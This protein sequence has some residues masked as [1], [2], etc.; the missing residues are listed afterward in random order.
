M[1]VGTLYFCATQTAYVCKLFNF[2]F[3]RR[4]FVK[5][6]EVLNFEVFNILSAEQKSYIN[7]NVLLFNCFALWYRCLSGLVCVLFCLSPLPYIE[8]KKLPMNSWYPFDVI[9][10]YY[11]VRKNNLKK[12]NIIHK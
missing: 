2:I 5:M 7:E 8:E 6:E 4:K 10:K 1:W 11:V 12:I 9:D 3:M